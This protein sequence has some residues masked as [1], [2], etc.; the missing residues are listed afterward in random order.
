MILKLLLLLFVS[1]SVTNGRS[2]GNNKDG[3]DFTLTVVHVND[4]HAHF[5]QVNEQVR[6]K[7]TIYSNNCY[8]YLTFQTGRC[9]TEQAEAE[10]CFGGAAR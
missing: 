4:I 7:S 8:F 10:Q 1:S 3:N 2:T 9:H 6:M 5:E